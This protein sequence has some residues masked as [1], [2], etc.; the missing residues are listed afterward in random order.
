MEKTYKFTLPKDKEV[1][2][3]IARIENGKVV[4]D[5]E[6]N[7]HFKPESGD[8]IVAKNGSILLYNGWHNPHFYCGFA[9]LGV[10]Q[11]SIVVDNRRAY[12]K[13]SAKGCRFA[14]SEE[15]SAFLSRLEKECGKKWNEENNCLEDVF[16]PKDGDFLVGN[17]GIFICKIGEKDNQLYAYVGE[18]NGKVYVDVEGMIWALRSHCRYA[19]TEEK[20]DFLVRLDKECHKR[21]NSET[22]QLED[23]RWRNEKPGGVFYCIGPFANVMKN[24][25][26]FQSSDNNLYEVGNYFRTPEASQKVADQIKEIFKNSKSE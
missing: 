9:I 11:D 10:N 26:L 13:V 15:K 25:D 17:T 20:S 24:Y 5:V 7:R 19:T 3:V 2:C 1:E 12:L 14:T 4:V 6:F 16:N 18:D 22:K 8:V 23:I 21:W